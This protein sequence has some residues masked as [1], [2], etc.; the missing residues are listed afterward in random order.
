MITV[1][2]N[3]DHGNACCIHVVDQEGGIPDVHFTADPHGGT[4]RLWFHLNI[5]VES[6]PLRCRMVLDNPSG[7]LGI[8]PGAAER[9]RPVL[10]C[11]GGEWDRLPGGCTRK[12]ADG[13]VSFV[14]DVDVLASSATFAFCFPHGPEE[15]S[16]LIASSQGAL[17]SDVIGVSQK[18]RPLVRVAN[19]Y[20]H[21]QSERPGIYCISHQHASEMSGAW[22]CHGFL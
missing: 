12:H 6:A 22:V 8:G 1:R 4:E 2:T 20:G 9:I 5:S 7:M 11:E 13:R 21:P 14:W 3:M 16:E 17:T 18:G 10:R 19:S 15:V